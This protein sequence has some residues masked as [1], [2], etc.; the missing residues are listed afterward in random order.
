[1]ENLTRNNIILLACLL[2]LV[3]LNPVLTALPQGL[4]LHILLSTIIVSGVNSCSFRIKTKRT[5]QIFGLSALAIIWL[6]FFFRSDAMHVLT[7]GSIFA[8]VVAIVFFL[9][10]HIARSQTVTATLIL[11]AINGYF[12]MGLLGALLLNIADIA[13]GHLIGT[14][15]APAIDVAGGTAATFHDYLYFGFVTLTTLGY[16]DITPVSPQA[17]SVSMVIAIAGQFYLTIL[18]AMLV[19]KYLSQKA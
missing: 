6:D 13:G 7:F 3:L 8:F 2:V 17:K 14:T 11:S 15:A 12:L 16:G 19:G 18:V 4:V 9:I 1:M 5:L 10:R